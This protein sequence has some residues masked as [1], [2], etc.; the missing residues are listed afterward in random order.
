MEEQAPGTCPTAQYSECDILFPSQYT[1][2]LQIS[3]TEFNLMTPSILSA[4]EVVVIESE[5]RTA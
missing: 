2:G 3:P 4:Q 1:Q 5:V